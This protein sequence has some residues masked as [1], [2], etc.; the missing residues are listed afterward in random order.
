MA[1]VEFTPSE[2]WRLFEPP[3][4]IASV[5]SA[6]DWASNVQRAVEDASL[7]AGAHFRVA[8]RGQERAEW[9]FTSSLYRELRHR[10][11]GRAISWEDFRDE[12]NRIRGALGAWQLTIASSGATLPGLAL[13]ATLQHLGGKTRLLDLTHSILVALWFAVAADSG[14]DGRVFA[15]PYDQDLATDVSITSMVDSDDLGWLE[16]PEFAGGVIWTAPPYERRLSRQ[17]GAFLLSHLPLDP[18]LRSLPNGDT[19]TDE[20][21]RDI[22]SVQRR[23]LPIDRFSG[24]EARFAVFTVRIEATAKRQIRAELDRFCSISARTLYPDL[25]GFVRFSQPSLGGDGIA[26]LE[27]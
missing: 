13:W 1:D 16:N 23:C 27:Y 8:Y 26:P 4:Q 22:S 11:I 10:I 2:Y 6:L 21:W 9:S 24:D 12:E 7:G 19:V 3:T 20:S 15:I 5:A 14:S 18:V 17:F 25:P